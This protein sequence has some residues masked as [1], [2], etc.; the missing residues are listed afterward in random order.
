MFYNVQISTVE[1]RYNLEVYTYWKYVLRPSLLMM[2]IY[3][4]KCQETTALECGPTGSFTS[5]SPN[6]KGWLLNPPWVPAASSTL[7]S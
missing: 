4:P 5:Y 3:N 1:H 2:G 6:S 7:W